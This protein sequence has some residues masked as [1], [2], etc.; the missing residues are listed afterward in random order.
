MERGQIRIP[1]FFY[2]VEKL[3]NEV[4]TELYQLRVT[5]LATQSIRR[6]DILQANE[7]AYVA[8]PDV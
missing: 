6:G 7:S 4:S 5:R 3:L 2:H 1:G 8:R